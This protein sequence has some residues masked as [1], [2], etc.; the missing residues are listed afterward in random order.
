MAQNDLLK[1]YRIERR[2]SALVGAVEKPLE[3]D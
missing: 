1:R 3:K 2:I